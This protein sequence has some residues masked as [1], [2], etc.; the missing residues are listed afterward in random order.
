MTSTLFVSGYISADSRRKPT[1]LTVSANA[2]SSQDVADDSPV[3]IR[4]PEVAAVEAIG[5]PFVIKA[6]QMKNRCMKVMEMHA[7]FNCVIAEL[8]SGTVNHPAFDSAA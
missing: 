8:I 1:D 7:V 6:Q 5:Q 2:F 4:Q 3:D